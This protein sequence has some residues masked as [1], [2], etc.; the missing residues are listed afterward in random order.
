MVRSDDAP[1]LEK[2]PKDLGV[3]HDTGT[4]G[5]HNS[6]AYAEQAVRSVEEGARSLLEHAGLPWCLWQYAVQFYCLMC[7][8][9]GRGGG[10][11]WERRRKAPFSGLLIPFG[12]LAPMHGAVVTTSSHLHP[13]QA[14]L[15]G[16]IFNLGVGGLGITSLC[17]SRSCVCRSSSFP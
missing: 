4:P 5:R 7:N 10:S 11:P 6:N 8:I 13:S 3:L 1:E 15:L 16:I 2:A 14:S 12:S 17:A 9:A